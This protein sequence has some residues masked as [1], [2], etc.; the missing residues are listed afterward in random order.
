MSIAASICAFVR[1]YTLV[2]SGFKQGELVHKKIVQSLLYAS[3]NDFYARVPTGR[4]MNRLTKDLRELDETLGYGIGNFLTNLFSLTGTLS[5]CVYGSSPWMIV[6]AV[7]VMLLC[8]RLR[9]YYMRTQREVIRI[10]A[11]TNSPIVSGFVSAIHGLATIRAYQVEEE[12]LEGQMKRIETNKGSRITREALESWFAFRLT[13]LSFCI[14]VL[15]IG[16]AMLDTSISPALVGL[17]LSYAFT[18]NDDIIS[19]TFSWANL[20]TRLVS[21]ERIFNFMKIEPEKAYEEYCKSWTP[22]EEGCE[23]VITKGEL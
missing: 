17:L 20:E 6:P 22:L 1:A 5:I 12:F 11:K 3:L 9:Q 8:N 2:L 4:I 16:W 13:M 18:L 19:L 10:E 21:V 15:S 14:S 7:I 23:Q